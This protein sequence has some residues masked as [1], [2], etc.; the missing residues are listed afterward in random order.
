M[1]KCQNLFTLYFDPTTSKYQKWNQIHLNMAI[2]RKNDWRHIPISI[3]KKSPISAD[4]FI[5]IP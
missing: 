1:S 3:T 2:F 4:L 5:D